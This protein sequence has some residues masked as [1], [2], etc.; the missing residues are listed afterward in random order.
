MGDSALYHSARSPEDIGPIVRRA[1][2]IS[3]VASLMFAI[4]GIGVVQ[5]VLNDPTR[6]SARWYLPIVIL[7]PT[8]AVLHQPFRAIGQIGL[9]SA[10]RC[11]PSI[12]WILILV[13]ASLI[14]EDTPRTLALCFLAAHVVLVA[15]GLVLLR[16]Y[17]R[18]TRADRPLPSTRTLLRFGLRAR[19]FK[20][21]PRAT[22]KTFSRSSS[23][24]KLHATFRWN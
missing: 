7:I 13:V 10:L 1:L 19:F 18:S 4:L 22:S 24:T 5:L 17:P 23:S 21:P 8:L 15:V 9:W 14:G 12:G 11:G 16:W 3:F 2:R 6:S 20:R